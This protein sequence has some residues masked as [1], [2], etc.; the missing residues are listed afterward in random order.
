M[1]KNYSLPIFT[2]VVMFVIL[3]FICHYR[4]NLPSTSVSM[5]EKQSNDGILSLKKSRLL[6]KEEEIMETIAELLGDAKNYYGQIKELGNKK[7]QEFKSK[8]D[9]AMGNKPSKKKELKNGEINI[10]DNSEKTNI[11][12]KTD[13]YFE[14]KIF[15]AFNCLENSIINKNTDIKKFSIILFKRVG[16][17]FIVPF[18]VLFVSGLLCIE[19]GASTTVFGNIFA[20]ISI[21]MGLYIFIKLLKYRILFDG[22]EKCGLNDYISISKKIGNETFSYLLSS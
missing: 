11:F 5:C 22:K 3:L 10:F 2:K 8:I 6:S 17:L 13:Y 21:L 9:D 20:V 14:K 18:L 15:K 1:D 19:K 4:N 16:L 12:K 7:V